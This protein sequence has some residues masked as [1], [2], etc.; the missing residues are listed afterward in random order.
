[1][2]LAGHTTPKVLTSSTE[3]RK[4]GWCEK[5][6][7]VVSATENPERSDG[8]SRPVFIFVDLSTYCLLLK[9]KSI[10]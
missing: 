10:L 9:L 5:E 1:L 8:R 3:I 4:R 7:D 2:P 6:K